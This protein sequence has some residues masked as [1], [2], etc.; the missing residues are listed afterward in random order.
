M[1][2]GLAQGVASQAG[3]TDNYWV[4]VHQR[5]PSCHRSLTVS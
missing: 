2:H 1:K 5:N 4:P 3:D